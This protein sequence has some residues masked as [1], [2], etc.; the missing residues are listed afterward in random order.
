MER[1]GRRK[2]YVGVGK[3]GDREGEKTRPNLYKKDQMEGGKVQA[4]RRR[5]GEDYFSVR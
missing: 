4:V 1:G 2:R 5:K 3:G